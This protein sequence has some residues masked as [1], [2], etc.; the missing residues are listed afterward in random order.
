MVAVGES[1]CVECGERDRVDGFTV[2]LA[3]FGARQS[4]VCL[5]VIAGHHKF[6]ETGEPCGECGAREQATCIEFRA[7]RR[8]WFCVACGAIVAAPATEG[9]SR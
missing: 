4:R 1:I 5:G 7:M 8:I 6:T 2:C 9:G 3:C